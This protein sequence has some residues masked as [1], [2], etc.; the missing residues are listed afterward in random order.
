MT[1]TPFTFIGLAF[2]AVSENDTRAEQSEQP[3]H[4]RRARSAFYDRAFN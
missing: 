2:G 1:T 3:A 4:A